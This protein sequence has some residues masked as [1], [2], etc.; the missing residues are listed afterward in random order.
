MFEG[1]WIARPS[2]LQPMLSVHVTLLPND[3][4]SFGFP[5]RDTSRLQSINISMVADTGYQSSIIPLKSAVQLGIQVEDLLPVKLVMR[6]AIKE[7]LGVMDAIII[8]VAVSDMA[9]STTST[10]IFCYVSNTMERAFLCREALV[11]LGIIHTW[12]P[13]PTTVPKDINASVADTVEAF[14][15][16]QKLPPLLLNS[17]HQGYRLLG[18]M[19]KP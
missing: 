2:K 19:Y 5:I 16:R 11:S 3:H 4:A 9:D 6:G 8:S 1:K 18:S 7:D 15:R 14:C 12:F 17:S 10:Q 13:G